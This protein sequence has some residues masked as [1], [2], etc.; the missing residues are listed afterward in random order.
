MDFIDKQIL[1]PI[2]WEKF[3][4]LTR[5][6]FA[7]VWK[8]PLFQK[9]GRSGQ[10]QHGVDVYGIPD[11]NSG[12]YFGVQ[13]KGKNAGYGAKASIGE[14]N[15]EL[16]KADKFKPALGHWVFATT[17]PNDVTLQEHARI[18][19][20]QRQ[21]EGK[22]SVDAIGW[23]TIKALLSSNQA[24]VEEFYPEHAYSFPQVMA[25]LRE[26]QANHEHELMRCNF[27]VPTSRSHLRKDEGEGWSELKFE[28]VRDIGPA[29]MGR[30]LGPA[31]VAACPTLPEVS[32]L[33]ADLERS[34][35]ARLAGV[36]G[37]GK[38]ISILLYARGW[39]VVRLIDAAGG[40]R[41][42]A[43]S[44]K[45]TLYIVDDAHLT[46]PALLREMEE[47]T[48]TSCWVL[49]AFTISD[50][51]GGF[52]G[53]IQLDTKRA[54]RV[55]ADGLLASPEETLNVVRRVDHR[56]GEGV[57]DERLDLRIEHAA[58]HALY[59]WQFCFILGGGW[60]RASAWA[61]SARAMGFDIVL[62]AAAIRQLATCDT[63]CSHDE[64]MR[65]IGDLLAFSKVEDAI[66]WLVSQRYL[67]SLDDLRCPHQRLSSVL[68]ASILD[69]QSIEERKVV[70]GILKNVFLDVDMPL[71][72]LSVLLGEL[73]SA[74]SYRRWS[75]LVKPEWLEPVLSRCW[76]AKE[77]LDI[78]H[79]CWV[80][81]NLNGYLP[82]EIYQLDKHHKII[83][84]WVILNPEG[85]CYAIARVMNHVFNI[86][87]ALGDKIIEQ[88]DPRTMALAI[89]TSDALHI[90]EIA[91]LISMMRV[92]NNNKWKECYL[93]YIDR[94]ACL[95][96]VSNWP[97]DAYLS[98]AAEFCKH[99]IDL[100]EEFGLTLIEAL[101][102][103]IAN[104]LRADP[105]EAF[106]ELNDIV[107]NSLRLYDPLNVYT[108]KHAPTRRMRQVGRKLCA[109][110]SPKVLASNLSNSSHRT[111]QAAAGLL[112]VMRKVSLKQFEATI[113]S[114]DWHEIEKTIGAAW[115]EDIGDAR[116]LLGIAYAIPAA[117]VAIQS[118]VERNQD[119]I[120]VMS[121]HLAAVAPKSAILHLTMGKKIG[122]SHGQ[123]VGWELGSLVLA[124]VA[125]S[126]RSLI[127]ILLKP[128]YSG[129]ADALSQSSP[130]FYQESLLFLR[131]LDQ[132]KP[133]GLTKVLD[134]IDVKKAEYGWRNALCG[135]WS[136][137]EAR[138][139]S[140]TRQTIS[141]LIQ[142]SIDRK[143]DLG[144]LARKL[145]DDYPSRSVPS[146]HTLEEIDLTQPIE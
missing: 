41:H 34:G 116:M 3:E 146:V 13:C 101:I 145:R 44:S 42:I 26:F 20:E 2:S 11:N 84:E 123:H 40:I 97:Q 122:I 92:R 56:I 76:R 36:P 93:K 9:N 83:S 130:S 58:K 31:D 47:R 91:Y 33:I 22:F 50:D 67:L 69:G 136:S 88:V 52:T 94:E 27:V 124:R 29:L 51:R 107:W 21:K 75:H 120:K 39:R 68:F 80:I 43:Q 57:Y 35:S 87:A 121:T 8:N 74:G 45:P 54:V 37:A 96:M 143:D 98:S 139:K 72:G 106:I 114:L 110:W 86:D 14:F 99:F 132:V 48:T 60:Q 142:R 141:L 18:I 134:N 119:N 7:A 81:S 70:S 64:L 129:L 46:S 138:V 100:D 126:D 5:A 61:S 105:Q 71:A 135:R 24:V 55:I 77:P 59:P 128:H 109:C 113:L 73:S 144:E 63:P 19:S 102:P 111:F 103:A 30:S 125:Q 1:P 108:G 65:L 79:A 89:N 32:L 28:T 112:S 25:T 133:C 137:N 23:D 12:K 6:L 38:S 131:L 4:D 85:A 66:T 117:R 53:A 95:R 140:Q 127:S 15:A 104:R 49:S 17:A 82:D 118:M 78:R 115:A 16:I 10:Q 90:S 62:S